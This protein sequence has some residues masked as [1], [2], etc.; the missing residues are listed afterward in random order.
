MNPN[1]YAACDLIVRATLVLALPW[2]I[3]LLWRRASAADRHLM[4]SLTLAALIV[5]PVCRIGLPEWRV[6]VLPAAASAPP[7]PVVVPVAT[8]RV[9]A[10]AWNQVP[11]F[12]PNQ[13]PEPKPADAVAGPTPET[14]VTASA[15]F[16]ISILFWV[17]IAGAGLLLARVAVRHLALALSARR[18]SEL[19]DPAIIALTRRAARQFHVGVPRILQADSHTMPIVWCWRRPALVLPGTVSTWRHEQLWA[20]LLH[21]L[22]H[23]RRRD[24]LTQLVGQIACAFYW[25]H[26]LAWLALAQMV[27]ER[28]R[29]CDDLVLGAGVRPSDYTTTLIA[30][31]RE[32]RESRILQPAL[33]VARASRLRE[34][35]QAILD[36]GK[37]RRLLHAPSAF[38]LS[39]VLLTIGAFIGIVQ[40]TARALASPL[41]DDQGA[42]TS[43]QAKDHKVTVTVRDANGKA[44]PKATVYLLTPPEERLH[45]LLKPREGKGEGPVVRAQG[46]T[47]A[48]GE[49]KLVTSID[50]DS[51]TGDRNPTNE[52]PM[53]IIARA[54]TGETAMMRLR[55]DQSTATLDLPPETQIEGKLLTPEGAPAKNVQVHQEW[56]YC[57]AKG[58]KNL[59][60]LHCPAPRAGSRQPQDYPPYWPP[61]VKTGDDGTFRIH[62]VPAGGNTQLAIVSDDFSRERISVQTVE[63]S[64]EHEPR[65]KRMVSP[66]FTYRLLPP[67][68]FEGT[69]TG[70]DTGK[71]L[72]DMVVQLTAFQ[73]HGGQPVTTITDAQGHY[74][75]GCE[76]A[77]WFYDITIYPPQRSGYL[78]LRWELER[79]PAPTNTVMKK[80]FALP[81]GQLVEGRVIAQP[82]DQPVAE[83][84][85]MYQPQAGNKA[86]RRGFAKF[87]YELRNPTLTDRD[88]KFVITVLPG[89]GFLLAESAGPYARVK[90][91]TSET[92]SHQDVF[93]QGYARI[94]VPEEGKTPHVEITVKQGI[95]LEARALQPNGEP[96]PWVQASCRSQNSW[97]MHRWDGGNRFEG[98]VF[99]LPDCVPGQQ[100]HVLFLQ[101]ELKL[102]AI[103]DL[104]ADASGKPIDVRL[105]PTASI[106]GRVT[107][108]DGSPASDIQTYAQVRLTAEDGAIPAD[109]FDSNQWGFYSNLLGVNVHRQLLGHE[110]RTNSKGEFRLTCLIPG[111]SNYFVA[112]K[113]PYAVVKTLAA[114][115]PGESR[116]LGTLV[117]MKQKP[118]K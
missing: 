48:Q 38:V 117:L 101:P 76:H 94:D 15:P 55:I 10:H 57:P 39:L 95:A 91:A 27:R 118:G 18:W 86:Y 115:K 30:V 62:A 59:E 53:G 77:D 108:K 35:I 33:P 106:F 82:S 111:A 51:L 92:G 97:H 23:I 45:Q 67:R 47:D 114:L 90:L 71:P 32:Y 41:A 52:A 116:D 36:S 43:S 88:G 87:D 113:H 21:E 44:V 100:Y 89:V 11:G 16:G 61:D 40:P 102:G 8:D 104:V 83:A 93:P 46:T 14:T 72:P 79:W 24:C 28:E 69:I 74:R 2:A 25:F 84:S 107:R 112:S 17:W 56:F 6:A 75:I 81:R 3:G 26:P 9:P 80:D 22:A 66:H 103:A 42:S 5:L 13:A 20:V 58:V 49:V 60:G 85:V 78:G 98:G 63:Q 68:I 12:L 19:T 31:A 73:K 96:V 65:D 1:D 109:H 105:Q 70:K 110:D 34:R 4:W 50:V 99:R 37:Q 64:N 29:A 54:P 7:L